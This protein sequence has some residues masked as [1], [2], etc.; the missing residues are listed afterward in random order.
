METPMLLT[1]TGEIEFDIEDFAVKT[2]AGVFYANGTANITYEAAVSEEVGEDYD[3]AWDI[4]SIDE[5]TFT[6]EN[7]EETLGES[8]GDEADERI[9]ELV[10]NL[11]EALIL[12]K[13]NEIEEIIDYDF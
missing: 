7:E 12:Y 5:L 2:D 9:G 10:K 1:A 4:A 13:S 11:M 8:E 3:I 6:S